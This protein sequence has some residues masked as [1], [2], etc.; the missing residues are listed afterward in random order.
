MEDDVG[1]K[2]LSFKVNNAIPM[3]KANATIS[4][5]SLIKIVSHQQLEDGSENAGLENCRSLTIYLWV[6]K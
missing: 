1:F 2:S 5:F 4:T 6:L 3:T